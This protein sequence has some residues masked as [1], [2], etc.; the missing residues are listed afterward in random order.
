[1]S[2][3]S[4]IPV[5]I[6][7][8]AV[9]TVSDSNSNSSL[10]TTDFMNLLLVQLQN[11]D[12]LEPMDADKMTDQLVSFNELEQ[13]QKTNTYLETL[14]QYQAS[15]GNLQSVQFMGKTVLAPG[16]SVSVAEGRESEMTFDLSESASEVTIE[17]YDENDQLVKTLTRQDMSS[18]EQT[19][20]WD[21]TDESGNPVPEGNY[22]YKVSAVDSQGDSVDVTTYTTAVIES[23]EFKDGVAYLITDQGEEIPYGQVCKVKPS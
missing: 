1:M 3:L 19:V 11:Q 22:S 9:P 20:T 12:P 4:L 2:G 18:G 16:N 5:D 6:A 7:A 13:S 10:N 23:I 21:G 17:I 14:L 8:Q 15:M